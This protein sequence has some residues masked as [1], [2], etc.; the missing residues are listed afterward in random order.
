MASHNTSEL[1]SQQTTNKPDEAVVDALEKVVANVFQVIGD[2]VIDS[3][4]LDHAVA[5]VS[6]G[7][8]TIFSTIELRYYS[9]LRNHHDYFQ[10]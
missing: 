8:S 4:S 3:I 7:I 2:R 1:D 9:I 10:K 6:G 5:S